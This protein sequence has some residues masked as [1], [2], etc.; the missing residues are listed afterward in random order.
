MVLAGCR[1]P[2]SPEDPLDGAAIDA[3][4]ALVALYNATDGPHWKHQDNWCTS[5]PLSE[6]Y[7]VNSL[8]DA[9]GRE[10]MDARG[11]TYDQADKD[12]VYNLC[13]AGNHLRGSIPDE[14][15]EITT[16]EYLDLENLR[17]LNTLDGSDADNWNDLSSCPIPESVSDLPHLVELRLG[18]N[19]IGGHLPEGLWKPS[20][21][22]L[23]LNSCALEGSISP[24]V[25]NAASLRVLHLQNNLLSG[26]IPDEITTLSALTLLYLGNGF[27]NN[28]QQNTFSG[29]IP[30]S[31]GEMSSLQTLDLYML[32]GLEGGV[33]EGIYGLDRLRT[34]NL[35]CTSL[36]GIV[37]GA[38]VEQMKSISLFAVGKSPGIKVKRPIPPSLSLYGNDILD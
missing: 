12:I 21:E 36:E 19:R 14:L 7:G 10:Y 17:G 37:Y 16:L 38:L 29:P 23:E 34:C 5:R 13:L 20:L 35:A 2:I 11:L 25:A 22:V 9:F 33:P 18:G 28:S 27:T 1:A 32:K 15:W 30:E 26:R 31:I 4:A 3:R 24:S 6:W 8:Y